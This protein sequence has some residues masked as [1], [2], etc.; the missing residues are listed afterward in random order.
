MGICFC[1][2]LVLDM[3]T[4]DVTAFVWKRKKGWKIR[5]SYNSS[6]TQADRGMETREAS[7]GKCPGGSP[8]WGT[9]VPCPGKMGRRQ[10]DKQI[11]CQNSALCL[12]AW[13]ETCQQSPCWTF[14]DF[15]QL[16]EMLWVFRSLS[17]SLLTGGSLHFLQLGEISPELLFIQSRN[18]A[19]E[20]AHA[21]DTL[22]TS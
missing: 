22:M 17:Y 18:N 16:H 4:D 19:A 21:R 5:L 11:I 3:K 20:E 6:A 1:F 7:I 12:S 10:R 2:A 9:L 8:S 15:S 14:L 13:Q